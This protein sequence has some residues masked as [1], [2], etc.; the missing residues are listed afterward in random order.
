MLTTIQLLPHQF[1][2]LHCTSSCIRAA[3]Y[4]R[5]STENGIWKSKSRHSPLPWRLSIGQCKHKIPI[6][7]DQNCTYNIW[8]DRWNNSRLFQASLRGRVIDWLNHIRD[9]WMLTSP[10]GLISN[11]NSYHTS[12]SRQTQ[13]VGNLVS[14]ASLKTIWK[15]SEQERKWQSPSIAAVLQRDHLSTA[16]RSH[17]PKIE[18]AWNLRDFHRS[19]P[20]FPTYNCDW[21]IAKINR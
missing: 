11:L 21:K 20:N 19:C 1:L 15:L 14:K 9:T 7:Q 18:V 2:Y 10:T 12:T 5:K 3:T 4:L 17:S 6:G 13:T 8:M 16:C